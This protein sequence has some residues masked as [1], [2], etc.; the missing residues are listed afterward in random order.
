LFF[1]EALTGLLYDDWF[2]QPVRAP[3]TREKA[4]HAVAP[5]N[6]IFVFIN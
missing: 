6:L 4:M 5:D 3:N 1:R 2:V